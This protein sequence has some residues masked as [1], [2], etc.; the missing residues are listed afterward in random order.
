MQ[1]VPAT[2]DIQEQRALSLVRDRRERLGS[3]IATR[4]ISVGVDLT[5]AAAMPAVGA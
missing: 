2:A 5:R 3:D 1:N 4:V